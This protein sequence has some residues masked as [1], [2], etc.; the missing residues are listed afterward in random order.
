MS[1][2]TLKEIRDAYLQKRDWEKQFPINF[3]LIRPI[4]FYLTFLIL[5]VTQNPANIALFGFALGIIGCFFLACSQIF[6]IWP[7]IIF[8][9]LYSLSDAV[10][11]NVARTTKNVTL[12]GKYLDGI[13]GSLIDGNYFFFLGIGMYFLKD[14]R[15][16]DRTLGWTPEQVGI[17]S[18]SLGGF[19]LISKL[20]ADIFKDRYESYKA[21]KEG[22]PKFDESKSSEPI[23]KSTFS[24]RWYFRLFINMD[25]LNNQL[26]LLALLAILKLEVL[27]L[28]GFACFY[29]L[30]S[31]FYCVFY[32]MRTKAA[33]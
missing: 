8:I 22:L 9:I 31:V 13:I 30:R 25:C 20:W 6:S 21:K 26:L 1:S 2:Y 11:G 4:S 5:K 24:R 3:F 28:I 15:W 29:T 7:G 32:F 17:L 27:F 14:Y 33:L 18:L 23:G 19:I 10:D 16:V 12:F